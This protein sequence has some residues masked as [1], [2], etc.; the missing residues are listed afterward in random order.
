MEGSDLVWRSHGFRIDASARPLV[1]VRYPTTPTLDGFRAAVD[2][3]VTL[4]EAGERIAWLID[5]RIFDGLSVSAATRRDGARAFESA[6]PT[7]AKV[8]ICEARVIESLIT[9]GIATAF[10]WLAGP[11]WPVT[12]VSTMDEARR[13]I[14]AHLH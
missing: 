5:L 14:A 3:F 2:H 7:L 6:R 11:P 4:A 12:A 1:V 13:W 8:T 10:D 9:R